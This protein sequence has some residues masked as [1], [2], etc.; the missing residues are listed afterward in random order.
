MKNKSIMEQTLNELLKYKIEEKCFMVTKE[1][2]IEA[3]VIGWEIYSNEKGTLC[4]E[5]TLI[6]DNDNEYYSFGDDL[7]DTKKQAFEDL[8]ENL[9]IKYNIK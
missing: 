6:G 8:I 4:I 5:Y 3:E 1:K 7:F 9:K 2:I